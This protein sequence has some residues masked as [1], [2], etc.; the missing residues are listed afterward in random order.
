MKHTDATKQKLS[1][2]RR[3]KLNPFY[4][5]TH[6]DETKRKIGIGTRRVNAQRQYDLDAMTVPL[7]D[8]HDLGYL[9]GI[10]D[11]EGSISI[12]RD[13]PQIAVYNSDGRLMDWLLEKVGGTV[14][15]GADKRGRVPGHTWHLY[16]AKNVYQA[17]RLL[18]PSLLLKHGMA[19]EVIVFLKNKYGER[20]HG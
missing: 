4:G 18:W 2:M 15:W 17:C 13:R 7:L 1:R 6:S 3:G 9:A 12:V 20:I 10:V 16:A 11:G 14:T 8:A 5:R 19:E